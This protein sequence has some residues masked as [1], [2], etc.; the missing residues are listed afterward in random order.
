MVATV[1][2][3]KPRL[4]IIRN[5]KQE[6]AEISKTGIHTNPVVNAAIADIDLK[7]QGSGTGTS[8]TSTTV[9]PLLLKKLRENRDRD[10]GSGK[11]N[12]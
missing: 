2:R 8:T 5:K 11:D 1:L 7:A 4:Q 6:L 10:S 9:I 3:R 12:D